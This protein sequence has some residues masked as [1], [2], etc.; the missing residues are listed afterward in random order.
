MALWLDHQ[1]EGAFSK[2]G[3]GEHIVQQVA[4]ELEL[5]EV[6]MDSPPV[7]GSEDVIYKRKV[8]RTE[9][10]AHSDFRQQHRCHLLSCRFAKH[11][12]GKNKGRR[13]FLTVDRSGPSGLF[14]SPAGVF[15]HATSISSHKDMSE[16]F[17]FWICN[18]MRITEELEKY[19][20]MFIK[21]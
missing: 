17:N 4:A 15:G 21:W 2:G 18:C 7:W 19:L 9:G 14:C 16:I 3:F 13:R 11:T 1:L 8:L 12:F 5:S 20:Y 6:S 10:G